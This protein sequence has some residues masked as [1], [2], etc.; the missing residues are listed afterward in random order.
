MRAKTKSHILSI[1]EILKDTLNL[2]DVSETLVTDLC[3]VL[4]KLKV[5]YPEIELDDLESTVARLITSL[6]DAVTRGSSLQTS[7]D[8]CQRET[9]QLESK[10][11]DEKTRRISDFNDSITAQDVVKEEK[12]SLAH[13]NS[14]LKSRI[15]KL[16][17]EISLMES[18]SNTVQR[19]LSE[20]E[21]FISNLEN[22]IERHQRQNVELISVHSKLAAQLRDAE[23]KSW[24]NSRWLE[25][26]IIESYFESFADKQT[27]KDSETLFF[28][29]SVT[30]FV[31]LDDSSDVLP[32]LEELSFYNSKYAFFCV[33]N[34]LDKIKSDSGDH[35][36]LLFVDLLVKQ[37]FHFDSLGKHNLLSAN[38][39]IER[40]NAGLTLVEVDCAKQ[41]NNYECG[42]N[43][44]MYTKLV[45][46]AY[47]NKM[48]QIPFL[49]WYTDVI[50][51]V[52]SDLSEV[53]SSSS[54]MVSPTDQ[55]DLMKVQLKPASLEAGG[56]QSDELG[57][58]TVQTSSKIHPSTSLD[59]SFE[60]N[61]PY[62]I[63]ST[64]DESEPPCEVVGVTPKSNK[65]AQLS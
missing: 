44:L 30:Q 23:E 9:A 62:S 43:V 28:G 22:Q 65:I 53:C 64:L 45:N 16:K 59:V 11:Q 26:K 29:P 63:L 19:L 61:N 56:E 48:L 27:S 25:D 33:G 38:I 52:N 57:W 60:H 50:L 1:D 42:L 32:I 12:D 37:A 49:D 6:S 17:D 41:N 18:Q 14:C 54:L 21:S 3:M 2:D 35:W 55:P 51:H 20:K 13:E 10:Y 58:V 46:E 47:C 4:N 31:K 15:S 36:S 7:L 40:L 5:N 39:L 8:T 34:N 24:H